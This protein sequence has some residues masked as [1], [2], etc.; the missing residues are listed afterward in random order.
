VNKGR[1]ALVLKGYP[2]LSET[3]IAQ[4]ILELE[5]AGFEL[6][7][8]S[9]RHPT[10]KAT[11]PVHAEI[12]ASRH[13]LP[14][15]LH[16][17]PGRVLKAMFSAFLRPRFWKLLPVFLK[18]FLRDPTVNRVRRF[19]QALVL[20]REYASDHDHFYV[21][22]L[23]TPCSVTRYASIMT[24]K[25]F[26]ISA[27]AKDI[28]TSPDWEIREKLADADWLVTCTKR[29]ASHLA[30][31]APQAHVQ[32]VYHGLDLTR[33][34][35]PSDMPDRRTGSNPS[36]AIRIV[37]VGRAVAKKGIDSLLEALA[38]VPAGLYWQWVHIGGG[39]LRDELQAQAQRLGIGDR[40]DF[41]GS[42]PQVE[43]LETY[44]S[45]DLFVLPCRIDENGDR[46]GLPNVIVEA[47]SQRLPVISTTI[48]GIPELV[49]SG[50]NGIL[51][52]PD[53]VSA[54]VSAIEELSSDADKR[55]QMGALGEE[56]VRS[57]FSHKQTIG[58]I[59]DLLN[60]SLAG[61]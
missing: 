46:D 2:R 18:D 61:N 47:Q 29:A 36:D 40:C 6:S 50:E 15:Y 42:L 27:H 3:F 5:R 48:S 12:K 24:A 32:L 38:R 30:K 43:V 17:E 10:D 9:L 41:R 28:W 1:I 33:F 45:S 13:Y 60:K 22:F 56:R 25:S 8:I 4:E 59:V 39:P 52:E 20:A 26:S 55:K 53:D 54:L 23:H 49:T 14:E 11:H 37:T 44:R 31:L 35:S 57:G 51:V 19:G 34:P 7:I 58:E 16:E 21:H